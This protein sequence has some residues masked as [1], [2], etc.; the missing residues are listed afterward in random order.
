MKLPAARLASPYGLDCTYAIGVFLDFLPC[1]QG[2]LILT[3]L[4]RSKPFELAREPGGKDPQPNR[5]YPL[6]GKELQDCRTAKP[7][8]RVKHCA[9]GDHSG[10][11]WSYLSELGGIERNAQAQ[12]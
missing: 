9:V 10:S 11:F 2:I 3:S 8:R 1:H 12:P 5:D 7:L 4:L 6:P